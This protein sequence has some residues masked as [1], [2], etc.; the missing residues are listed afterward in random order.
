MGA[1]SPASAQRASWRKQCSAVPAT[2]SASIS[3]SRTKCVDGALLDRRQ[4]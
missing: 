3:S 1:S 4:H 2:V